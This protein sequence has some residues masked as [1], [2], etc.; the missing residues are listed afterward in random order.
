MMQHR[1]LGIPAIVVSDICMGTMTLKSQVGEAEAI[2]IPDKS[3][4]AGI[5]FTTPPR[6][7]RCRPTSSRVSGPREIVAKWF[8]SAARCHHPRD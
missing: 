2:R 5:D 3:F 1:R 4:D 6:V 7:I 8:T